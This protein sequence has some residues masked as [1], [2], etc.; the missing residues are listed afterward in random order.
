MDD[1]NPPLKALA[2]QQLWAARQSQAMDWNEPDDAPHD[3]L[4]KILWWD[5]K[6]YNTPYP[7]P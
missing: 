2:G 4:N 6:G 1:M 5:S 7:K 3:V